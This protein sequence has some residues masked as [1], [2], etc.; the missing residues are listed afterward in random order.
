MLCDLLWCWP[1]L[2]DPHIVQKYHLDPQDKWSNG[3]WLGLE[4]NWLTECMLTLLFF[5]T[6]GLPSAQVQVKGRKLSSA[7]PAASKVIV[8]LYSILQAIHQPFG[9]EA[10]S[11][12]SWKILQSWIGLCISVQM[13]K[14][15]KKIKSRGKSQLRFQSRLP[16]M[17]KASVS[18]T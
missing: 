16:V 15:K 13:V 4:L 7:V 6:Q 9:I 10:R 8:G 5:A 18:I 11:L 17:P 3:R 1:Q 2:F 12:Q 14:K